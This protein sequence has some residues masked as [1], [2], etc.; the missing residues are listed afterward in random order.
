MLSFIF[1]RLYRIDH[2]SIIFPPQ[3][4]FFLLFVLVFF[5]F[6]LLIS[7]FYLGL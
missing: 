6:F 1:R 2:R 7:G 3:G 5:F 4:I